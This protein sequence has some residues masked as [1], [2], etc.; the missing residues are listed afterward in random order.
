MS[1]DRPSCEIRVQMWY[2]CNHEWETVLGDRLA[3]AQFQALMSA[4]RDIVPEKHP[5]VLRYAYEHV[6]SL[7]DQA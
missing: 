7:A 4:W 2:E 6:R 1:E 3:L 5:E